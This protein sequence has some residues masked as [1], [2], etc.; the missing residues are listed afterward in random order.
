M[1][2]TTG[3][4]DHYRGKGLPLQDVLALVVW[5]MVFGG[6]E[7]VFRRRRRLRVG[8]PTEFQPNTNLVPHQDQRSI[9]IVP[10]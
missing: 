2:H 1:R 8:V 5:R 7:N 10:T 4:L 6:S 3:Q 9:N